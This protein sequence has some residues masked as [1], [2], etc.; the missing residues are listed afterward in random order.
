MTEKKQRD[1][2]AGPTTK[3]LKAMLKLLS[4]FGVTR[5]KDAEFEIEWGQTPIVQEMQSISNVQPG[6]FNFDNY[7]A[8]PEEPGSKNIDELK[9]D[10]LGFTDD[11]YLWRSAETP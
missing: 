3:K 9:R 10:D 2:G 8:D 11:D 4:D 6:S 7:D 5:Y 1:M